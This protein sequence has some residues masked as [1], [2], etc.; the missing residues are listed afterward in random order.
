M[1]TTDYFHSTQSNC[2]IARRMQNWPE[3]NNLEQLE[4]NLHFKIF[5]LVF[6]FAFEL[7]EQLV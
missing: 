4:L 1:Q 6:I 2:L 3:N 7:E 5:L